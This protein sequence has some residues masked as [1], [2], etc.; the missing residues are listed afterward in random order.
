MT[1]AQ[2]YL[3]RAVAHIRLDH[4]CLFEYGCVCNASI[5]IFN[6]WQ[7]FLNRVHLFGYVN[8]MPNHMLITWHA[9]SL[10]FSGGSTLLLYV[11]ETD[12]DLVCV[13][14]HLSFLRI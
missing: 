13:D 5:P 14:F 6:F 8:A 12:F 4:V 9:Y 11:V 3:C 1:T 7:K 2:A 10:H